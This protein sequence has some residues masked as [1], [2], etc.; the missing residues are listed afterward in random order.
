MI[1]NWWA[2]AALILL[3]ILAFYVGTYRVANDIRDQDIYFSF[4]EG[5]RI[6]NFINPYSRIHEGDMVINQ[7]YATYF[8]LFYEFSAL[9]IW[10]GLSRFPH[11]LSFWQIV[12]QAASIGVGTLIFWKFY[13]KQWYLLGILAATLW[14]FNGWTIYVSYVVHLDFLAVFPFVLALFLYPRYR[15]LALLAFGVSLAIKQIAIFALPLFLIWEWQQ[16]TNN[17]MPRLLEALLL[18][19]V[20]PFVSSLPFL[21][22]DTSGFIKS[23]LFSVTRQSQH[24]VNVS[25]IANYFDLEGLGARLPLLISWLL[26]LLCAWKF[27]LPKYLSAFL[28]ILVFTEF[29]PVSF[30]QYLVWPAALFPFV[31]YE[32]YEAYT[33]LEKKTG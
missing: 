9:S 18:I 6:T 3:S 22:Q 1:K 19:G 15:R 13:Q 20:I 29:N 7:K 14:Y 30:P 2:I 12:F 11:W 28:V 4:V 23:T 32:S 5:E 27:R 8:P 26:V 25:D 33:A 10:F 16:P 21:W 24:V 31:I 17:K